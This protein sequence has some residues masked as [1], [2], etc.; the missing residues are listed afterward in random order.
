MT[1]LTI[2]EKLK[3]LLD[4]LLD[5][6]L[7][8]ISTIVLI[9]LTILYLVKLL[10]KKKY[11]LSIILTFILTFT[12]SIISNYKILST[13]FDNFMTIFIRGIYF[14]SIYAYIIT[15]FVVLIAFIM[16]MLSTKL[17]KRYKLVNIITF[18]I[19]NIFLAIVLNIIAKNKIDVFSINSLYTNT[20]LVVVLE[21][22]IGMIILWILSLIVLYLTD[23]I[24]LKLT[25]K[26]KV[27]PIDNIAINTIEDNHIKDPSPLIVKREEVEEKKVLPL[28]VID[29]KKED[30]TTFNDILNGKLEVIYYDN[31]INNKEYSITDPQ[32]TYESK[33]KQ[34]VSNNIT[35]QD[36]LTT[37]PEVITIK[38][39]KIKEEEE[40]IEE[41]TKNTKVKNA[42]NRLKVNTVSLDSLLE[43]VKELPK[44]DIKEE[45]KEEVVNKEIKDTTYTI[46]DYKL[47]VGMLKDIKNITRN[48]NITIEDAINISLI[49]NHSIEDCL[50]FKEIL[51]SNLN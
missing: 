38:P 22:N 17:P 7:I 21:L 40:K 24:T 14:P 4:I 30:T 50:K 44:E 10:N 23:A 37:S 18:I 16:T 12:I 29:K 39:N 9:I 31:N 45:V 35:I 27:K 5:Y 2:L 15:L 34:A 26:K 36:I 13:V 8:L 47:I 48:S 20:N 25:S 51:E 3:V 32:K 46:E 42:K 41:I 19:N 33:Y 49:S 6:K 11:T 1:Y 28:E 43:E